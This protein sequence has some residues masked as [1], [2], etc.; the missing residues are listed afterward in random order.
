MAKGLF[1]SALCLFAWCSAG[2]VMA[3][4]ISPN[5]PNNAVDPYVTGYAG[6]TLAV[7]GNDQ[8]RYALSLNG[9]VWR[10]DGAGGWRPLPASPPQGQV[11][12]VDPLNLQHVL[13]GERDGVA[14]DPRFNRTGVWET[15]DGG[16]TWSY[17][18]N[19]TREGSC[20][21][22]AISSVAFDSLA[23]AYAATS[24]GVFQRPAGPG[25]K[26]TLMP[27]SDIWG[28]VT[29]VAT[30]TVQGK[31]WVW[32]R[33][34]NT[35][36]L[37][38]QGQ[39]FIKGQTYWNSVAIPGD[40]V[41]IS[42]DPAKFTRG[43]RGDDFALA[44]FDVSAFTIA[45][46]PA[47]PPSGNPR[48][49]ILAYN[50][51]TRVWSHVELTDGDGTG[52]GGR[53]FVKAYAPASGLGSPWVL[54]AGTAQG[55]FLGLPANPGRGTDIAAWRRIAQPSYPNSECQGPTPPGGVCAHFEF[56]PQSYVHSDIW[57]AN[58]G[59]GADPSIWISGDGGVFHTLLANGMASAAGV[60]PPY[61]QQND[62]LHTHH[63]H[64]VT[65]SDYPSLGVKLAYPTADNDT[66]IRYAP[67]IGP[68]PAW[69]INLGE[70]GDT[71]LTVADTLGSP[72]V[73]SVRSAADAVLNS[74]QSFP[75]VCQ[76]SVSDQLCTRA[77]F[78][79]FPNAPFNNLEF[80]NVVQT[81]FGDTPRPMI[82][83]VMLTSRVVLRTQFFAEHPDG[84]A[85]LVNPSDWQ[86]IGDAPPNPQRVWVTGGHDHPT[87]FVYTEDPK[88]N[89][90]KLWR[91]KAQNSTCP[92]SWCESCPNFWCEITPNLKTSLFGGY[93][94]EFG[95][96]FV[97]PFNI[98]LFVTTPQGVKYSADGGDTFADDPVLDALIT[99]S[100]TFPMSSAYGGAVDSIGFYNP[101]SSN[102]CSGAGGCSPGNRAAFMGT[103]ANVAW[104]RDDGS[105]LAVA[106]PYTGAF[107][108]LNGVWRDLTPFLPTPLPVVSSVAIEGDTVYVA[109]EGRGLWSV[110]YDRAPLAYYFQRTALAPNQLA[111]LSRSDG[112]HPSGKAVKVMITQS[113]GSPVFTGTEITDSTGGVP[114]PTTINA[115]SIPLIVHLR[116]SLEGGVVAAM[117]FS[118]HDFRPIKGGSIQEERTLPRSRDPNSSPG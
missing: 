80:F 1:K 91:H 34:K 62:G 66:W 70:E 85:S 13:V 111:R 6:L 23:N 51:N 15:V 20:G 81:G 117:S 92:N 79:I 107:Y 10:A 19:P 86:V 30:Q 8:T 54:L 50:A 2:S 101:G 97:D 18:L 84:G 93:S 32:A 61:T 69:W 82:D 17:V 14:A 106:A 78:P 43:S 24:C 31:I 39:P 75:A 37:H 118:L 94:A 36:Y 96:A 112:V 99:G 115:W 98:K 38:R 105:K 90:A 49:S 16:S 103:L 21:F 116:A 64:A 109:T 89:V 68:F 33:S 74:F 114:T 57:D 44:A 40:S 63:T 47:T 83:L 108:R 113:N 28:T 95:P 67:A 58:L 73:M 9:G 60:S 76:N 11:I 42:G 29:A 55:V 100:G 65:V 27:G 48:S 7:A 87:Y 45:T 26:F 88:T 102:F 104:D 46:G 72:I 25:Q 3:Q 12:T 52:F 22:R 59:S 4:D 53:R 41:Q 35:L 110:P 5:A 56:N 71:S 77:V